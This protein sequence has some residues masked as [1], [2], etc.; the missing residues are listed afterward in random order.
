MTWRVG[1]AR[2]FLWSSF[3]LGYPHM[4]VLLARGWTIEGVDERYGSV[5]MSQEGS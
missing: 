1:C 5:L 3:L 4:L 2:T